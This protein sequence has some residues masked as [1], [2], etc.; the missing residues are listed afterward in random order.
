MR[1]FFLAFLIF[2]GL[3]AAVISYAIETIGVPPRRLAP[4]VE[5]RA[6]GHSPPIV[7]IGHG[8]GQALLIAD[9]GSAVVS[10]LPQYG[11]IGQMTAAGAGVD[12]LLHADR[13]VAI[14]FQP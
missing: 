8:I 6:A 14:F 4:Y 12:D 11:A 10:S 1:N 7:A 5:R 3:S 13:V 9:R 2:M